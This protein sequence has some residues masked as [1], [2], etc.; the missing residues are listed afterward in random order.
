MKNQE[1]FLACGV[2]AL[3]AGGGAALATRAFE[4]GPAREP[5]A[6]EGE[7]VS[8]AAAPSGSSPELARALDDLRMENTALTE[9]LSM[10]EARIAELQGTRTPITTGGEMSRVERSADDAPDGDLRPGTAL[11]VSPAFVASVSKALDAIKAKEEAERETK[12]K[13]LQAQRIEERVTRLQQ[14]LGLTN[15]QASD[16]RTALIAQDDKREVLFT[17]MR[18]GVGDPRDL[19]DSFRVIRDETNATLQTILT[20]EQYSGFLQREDFDFGRRGPPDF[21][22]GRPFGGD[23]TRDGDRPR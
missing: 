7:R 15:R 13:E 19:R 9:R 21:T 5:M 6:R 22:G 16:L 11:D 14:E 10:L 18:D 3:V 20:P 12:R 23:P 1:L 17:G 4:A 8:V 2:V